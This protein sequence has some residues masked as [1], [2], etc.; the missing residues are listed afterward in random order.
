MDRTGGS[1]AMTEELRL[2]VRGRDLVFP[3]GKPMC[4][5]CGAPPSGTRTVWFES[6][7]GDL[8]HPGSKGAALGTGLAAIASRI[9]FEAP[10]CR[11]HR[12]KAILTGLAA[13]AFMLSALGVIALGAIFGPDTT[14]RKPKGDLVQYVVIGLS[15]IP[16]GFGY[17]FWRRKDRGGLPCDVRREG[18]DLVLEYPDR[19]PRAS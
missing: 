6:P 16:G 12:R 5:V 9:P 17:F 15:L 8:S 10:L 2:R 4:L 18:G 19:A 1:R 14:R 3:D 11:G 13:P 7:R